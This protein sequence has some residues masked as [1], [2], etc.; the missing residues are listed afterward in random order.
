MDS[1]TCDLLQPGLKSSVLDDLR[2]RSVGG[3]SGDK[4]IW[5][6]PFGIGGEYT[7]PVR[8]RLS[9]SVKNVYC[10]VIFHDA[11]G[12]PI[13][14]DVMH[15]RDPI[16]AGLVKWVKSKVDDSVQELT[17]RYD[18]KTPHTKV[19]FRILDFKIIE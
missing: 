13:D 5:K 2:G 18:V 4:F 3:V 1:G 6:S 11:Q 16:P 12:D 9:E 15:F 17:T 14:V 8:N 7:F 10:L 19:E